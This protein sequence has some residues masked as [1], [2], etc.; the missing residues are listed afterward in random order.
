ML[1]CDS[2]LASEQELLHLHHFIC[3]TWCSFVSLDSGNV[4]DEIKNET[5]K[6]DK[7]QELKKKATRTRGKAPHCLILELSALIPLL[8][9]MKIIPRSL[10]L[11][12]KSF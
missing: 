11:G 7:D 12:S 4:A 10:P 6:P 5:S 3:S 1:T 8:I 9:S 2:D